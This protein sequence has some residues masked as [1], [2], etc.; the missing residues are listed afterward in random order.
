MR[1]LLIVGDGVSV[2]RNLTSDSQDGWRNLADPVVI[3]DKLELTGLALDELA[4]MSRAE[5][6]LF[7]RESIRGSAMSE[8]VLIDEASDS[9]EGKPVRVE[10][11]VASITASTDTV[12]FDTS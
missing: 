9:A 11:P 4:G 1:I 5:S 12:A 10:L 8:I 3:S 7:T 2:F 6:V